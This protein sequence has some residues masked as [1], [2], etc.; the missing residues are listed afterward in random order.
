M[1]V[2]RSIVAPLVVVGL[3]VASGGWLLQRGVARSEN[4]Y[5][6][7]RVLQEVVDRVRSSYVDTV[8]TGKL[9]NAAIEGVV[10]ELHDP[11][12]VFVPAS[13][14]EEFRIRTE[15]NYGGV[16]LEVIER[17]GYVTVVSP[18]PGTPGARAGIRAGDRFYKVNGQ[19][20]SKVGTD[21]VVSILRGPPGT[22]VQVEMLRPGVDQ[23]I[24]F[25]L[26]RAAIQLKAVPFA[27]MLPGGVGYIPFQQVLPTSVREIRTAIDSLKGLGMKGLVLDLRGNPGG[28]L[29]Q[30]VAVSDLFLD[31]GDSIVETRGRDPSQNEAFLATAPD[32]Y[33][34]LPVVVLVNGLS[35]SASEIVSGALQDNDRASTSSPVETC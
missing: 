22:E 2:R 32:R 14:D 25:T 35:A 24:P 7:V 27:M 31:K 23:P 5:V 15:G 29:D 28:L 10:K 33:P 18:I 26:K 19:D 12:S 21:S 9:Y 34:D 16:G 6:K 30:G 11:Y 3:S 4:V 20:V 8:D 1:S 13:Q 17:N